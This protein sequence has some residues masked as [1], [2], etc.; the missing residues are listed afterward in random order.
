MGLEALEVD[1]RRYRRPWYWLVVLFLVAFLATVIEVF[2][3]QSRVAQNVADFHSLQTFRLERG[4]T[5]IDE[6]LSDAVQLVNAE[7]GAVGPI[8]GDRQLVERLL[9]G[10]APTR[11]DRAIYGMG[12]FYAPG[13]F[14]R[15]SRLFGP[16]VVV[17]PRVRLIVNT[18]YMEKKF[19]YPALTWYRDAVRNGDDWI[20]DG[21]YLEEGYHY[22]SVLRAFYRHGVLQ[23]VAS[24]DT[25]AATFG[26]VV[27]RAVQKGK[28]DTVWITNRDGER[29]F[30]T[31]TASGD[32]LVEQTV[33]LRIVPAMLHLS[34]DASALDAQDGWIESGAIATAVI[35]W[36]LA[37]VFAIVIVRGWRVREAAFEWELREAR[38]R[39]EIEA[40]KKLEAGLRK[41]AFTDALTGLPNRTPFLQAVSAAMSHVRAGKR[42]YAVFFIDLDRFNMVNDTLGH[43]AGDELLKLVARRLRNDLPFEAMVARLGGDEFV[44]LAP[45]EPNGIEAFARLLLTSF[46]QPITLQSRTLRVGASFGIVNVDGDYSRPDELLRDADIAMFHAKL[47]GR[48]RYAVFDLAMRLRVA[49][50]SELENDLRLGIE[51]H[52]FFPCYQP[53]FDIQ[54]LAIRSFEA[55]VRWQRPGRG[56][57]NAAEFI[58]F[59]EKNGLIDAIDLIMLENV[60]THAAEIAAAFPQ[61]SIAVNVSAAHLAAVDLVPAIEAALA[62]HGLSPSVLKIEVTETAVMSNEELARATMAGLRDLGVQVVLDDFGQGHSSLAYLQRLP[63]AGL[64]IDR[65]FIEPLGTSAQALAIV[66]SIVSLAGS[67]GLYTVAEGVENDVQLK[68]LR[69]LGVDFGQGHLFAPALTLDELLKRAAI[70]TSG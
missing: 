15:K 20:V 13:V 25:R 39:H 63:I 1:A 59:A 56:V 69:E 29:Q 10:M 58:G 36:I 31:G 55:L 4:E 66:R 65:C 9:L 14:D 42:S 49:E 7:A 60:C 35:I 27:V 38:L 16:Y 52:E 40:A 24:V 53:L 37:G 61:S 3:A 32:R 64:K 45:V 22:I 67:L 11:R 44:V 26:D 51:K 41:A 8:H 30:S 23:G 34:S 50:A 48:G 57:V 19:D 21:P 68:F 70:G 54:S 2:V 12:I 62:A 43:I 5:V 46:K 47:A 33:S 18:E 28:R 17:V 6:F